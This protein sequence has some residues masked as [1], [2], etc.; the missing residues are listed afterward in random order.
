M[1]TNFSTTPMN[2]TPALGPDLA[3]QVRAGFVL[4]GTTF[5][6]FCLSVGTNR[7]NARKALLGTWKGPKATALVQQILEAS[8]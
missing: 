3:R 8:R 2:E 1:D 5:N 6:K 7:Q 4:K